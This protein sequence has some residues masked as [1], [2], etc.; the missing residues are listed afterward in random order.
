MIP[1]IHIKRI[2]CYVVFFKK[3]KVSEIRIKFKMNDSDHSDHVLC[4]D[5]I[6]AITLPN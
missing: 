1:S 4:Y 5:K 6:I 2:D 3:K